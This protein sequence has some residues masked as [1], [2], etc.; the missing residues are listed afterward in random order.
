MRKKCNDKITDVS[1][2]LLSTYLI[3][4]NIIT[5]VFRT[6]PPPQKKKKKKIEI[7]KKNKTKQFW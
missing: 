6:P 3:V 5:K 7:T 4:V 1:V 2:T